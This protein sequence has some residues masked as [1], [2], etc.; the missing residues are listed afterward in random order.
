[1]SNS[2]QT[3]STMLLAFSVCVCSLIALIGAQKGQ[4]LQEELFLKHLPDGRVL[5]HFEF[6][7]AW[8]IHPLA[9]SH[10]SSGE[11]Y[12]AHKYAQQAA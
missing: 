2:E 9:F 10:P 6:T 3:M 4:E 1:M 8:H 5:A 7:T 11:L 12:C